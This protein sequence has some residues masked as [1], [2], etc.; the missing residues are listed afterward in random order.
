MSE[1]TVAETGAS[2]SPVAR[3]I[4]VITSPRQTFEDI[5]RRPTWLLPFVL[6]VVV[7]VVT[8]YLLIDLIADAQLEQMQEQQMTEQ[9][10]EMASKMT[11][12]FGWMFAVVTIP[13]FYVIAAAVLLFTGNIVLGGTSN[14][15]TIFSVSCWAGIISVVT[16]AISVP[17]M[18]ARGVFESPVSLVFL[19]PDDKKSFLYNFFSSI[20]LFAL[21][22]V[23]VMGIGLAAAYRWA[24][25]KGVMVTAFWWLLMVVIGAGW[26]AMFS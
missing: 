11:R 23:V 9:Q 14:F 21:W 16:S 4:G 17:I 13:L 10:I 25:Q 26:R 8:S 18:L 7:S 15:R 19:A 22:F 1:Q 2:M 6:V 3:M 5:V 24:N 20:D 12:Q